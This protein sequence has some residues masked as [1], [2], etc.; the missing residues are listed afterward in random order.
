MSASGHAQEPS[1]EEREISDS[2]TL[3]PR[4]IY[5]VVRRTG[6][7]ELDRP[8]NALIWSGVTAGLLMSFSVLGEALL[9]AALP[10]APWR[11][12]IENLG[13]SLGFLLVILGR[14]QLFTENT[15][16]TV[17][18]VL[19]RCGR[20]NLYKMIRL[21]GVVLVSNVVGAFAIAGF[22]SLEVALPVRST[23]RCWR[24]RPMRLISARLKA[25]CAAFL[26]AS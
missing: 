18:P 16:T 19:A 5:E 17:L 4:L 23:R 13:Y 11:A 12:I 26:P 2:G 14:M 15:I 20:S 7:E 8:L 9:H 1:Q 25:S 21:W 6:E 22:W 24:S 10:E 3:A